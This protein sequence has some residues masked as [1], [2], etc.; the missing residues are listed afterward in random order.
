VEKTRKDCRKRKGGDKG[1][2]GI[3]KREK[4]AKKC[5]YDI[6]QSPLSFKGLHTSFNTML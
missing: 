6:N 5:I 3:R 4:E 2:K 1:I